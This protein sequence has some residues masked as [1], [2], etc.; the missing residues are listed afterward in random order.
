MAIIIVVDLNVI[1]FEYVMIV[2]LMQDK[3]VW[4]SLIHMLGKRS[5]LPVVAF[6]FSRNRCNDN[7][8]S[9]S[10]L[11]L[12]TTNEKSGIH[13]FF[14][15]SISILKGCDRELPQVNLHLSLAEC[16]CQPLQNLL[17]AA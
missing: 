5:L 8:D 7:A 3:N 6:T 17:L 1:G 10:S 15:K 2:L 9:L 4:L 13:V 12:T 11:D 16:Q 14:Q